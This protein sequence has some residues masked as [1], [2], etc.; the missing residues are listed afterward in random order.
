MDA[1]AA[2]VVPGVGAVARWASGIVVTGGETPEALDLLSEL[3]N[4]I[5]SDPSSGELVELFRTGPRFSTA[6]VDVAAAVS[7]PDG[8]RVF[9]RGDMQI[10]TETNE[11]LAGPDPVEQDLPDAMALWLGTGNPPTSQGHPVMDL[12]RGIVTGEGAVIH[13]RVAIPEPTPIAGISAVVVP[14]GAEKAATTIPPPPV[15]LQAP[16]PV[17]PG[18]PPAPP[19]P[20]ET[21]PEPLIRP[22][23]AI[24]WEGPASADNREPLEVLGD[25]QP[26]E[27]SAS[28]DDRVLGIH[29]IRGHFNNPKAGYCQVC[30]ISMV[31]VTHR[32]EPGVRPTL[33]FVVFADG[34]TYAVDRPYLIGRSPQPSPSSGLTPLP[35][36]DAT[37]SVSREHAE[38]R[39]EEWDVTY[40]DLGSTNGS[41]LWNSLTRRWDPIQPRTQVVLESGTTVSVGRMTFVF[42]GASRAVEAQ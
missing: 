36:Q 7:T 38:L 26:A 33:G 23:E 34:A 39:L 40:T 20:A 27:E 2:Q 19:E 24:D 22:F 28:T 15:A 10:R 37:Q 42:E 6:L 21:K 41:F 13:R 4:A 12:Q 30:G 16:A 9:V 5:G 25:S 29:C 32:L 35:T 18:P 14:E 31:H 8:L 17:T 11:L 3:Q 1:Y